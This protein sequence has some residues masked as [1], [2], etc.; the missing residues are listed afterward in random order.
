MARLG[1]GTRVRSDLFH[2]LENVLSLSNLSEDSVLSIEMRSRNEAEEELRS[3]GV[4]TSVGH[5]EDTGTVVLVN[6]VLIVELSSVD[7]FTSGTV[8][9]SEIST[10]CHEA[11][12]DSVPDAA[13]VVEGLS[14]F[15]DSLLSSA[16]S[17]EVLS[18]LGGVGSKSHSDASSSLSTNGDVEENVSHD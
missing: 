10:L 7:R 8:S 4:G 16:E 9:N 13:L 11:G 15:T 6:E 1:S 18:G 14:R 2:F 3:V 5:G 12:D 17:S